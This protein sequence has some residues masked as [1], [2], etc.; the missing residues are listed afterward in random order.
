MRR[1]CRAL[2]SSYKVPDHIEIRAA[3]PVTET[4]KL[5]RRA[6]REEA[7]GLMRHRN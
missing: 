6:L 3:L 1:H 5:H 4:G 2:A 7:E